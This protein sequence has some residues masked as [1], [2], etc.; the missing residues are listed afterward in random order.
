MALKD[1]KILKSTSPRQISCCHGLWEN[2]FLT[3]KLTLCYSGA[4][5]SAQVSD[6]TGANNEFRT[7]V[8]NKDAALSKNSGTIS[9]LICNIASSY[10]LISDDTSS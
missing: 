7:M 1:L 6:L 8:K 2:N 3:L 4:K 5:L 10:Y 9:N